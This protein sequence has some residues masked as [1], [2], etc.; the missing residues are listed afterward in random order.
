MVSKA[1]VSQAV[2]AGCSGMC[3]VQEGPGTSLG[4]TLGAP[5]E[6][7]DSSRGGGMVMLLRGL[8]A[9]QRSVAALCPSHRECRLN[10]ICWRNTGYHSSQLA[11][12][13][14]PV[15]TVGRKRK[16][17]SWAL[18]FL[19]RA[20]GSGKG[21]EVCKQVFWRQIRDLFPK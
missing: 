15:S 2:R 11:R 20:P 13:R 14:G 3:R 4:L 6:G 7:R 16:E 12:L 8:C 18:R 1:A 19:A 21:I 9:P 10:E 5:A 17:W